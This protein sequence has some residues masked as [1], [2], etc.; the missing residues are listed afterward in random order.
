M[1]KE[2]PKRISRMVSKSFLWG[3]IAAS[4]TWSISLYLYWCLTNTSNAIGSEPTLAAMISGNHNSADQQPVA[5][6]EGKSHPNKAVLAAHEHQPNLLEPQRLDKKLY[7]EKSYS[8]FHEKLDRYNKEKQYRKISHKLMD[9]LKPIVPNGT[10]EFGMVRNSEEQFIRD[11]GYRKHAFNVLVSNKIGSFRYIPDTR[12]KLCLDQSYDKVLPSASIVMCFYNEHQQTL[13]RSVNSVIHRTPSYLLHEIVLVDDCSDYDDLKENLES[14]LKKLNSTKIKII[15]NAEREGLMRS[16]VIGARNSTGEVLIF[17]DSHIEVN[18]DWIEPLLQR[19]KVNST[20]LAMPVIDIINS[21]TFAYTSSPL[22]RGGFNWGLHFKWDNLPRGTLSKDNDFVG[23]FRSPTMAGGL[24][25][26]DRQYFKDLGEYDMGMDVW[27]GENLEISFRAWQC[28]GSIELLP[29]SRIG[30][31]FRKRRPYGSPNGAD[32]MIRNSLRLAHVWMDDYIKYYLENQPQAK[33]ID[34][35]DV[36]ERQELRNRLKCKSF[37]WYLKNIYP[38]LRLPGEKTIDSNVSQ[39]KFQPWHSR[40]RNYISS[41]QVRLSNSSLCVTTQGAKEKSLW[42]K[43][44]KLVLQPCLRVKTQMWYETE[45]SELVLGQ[46][47]CLEAPSSATKGTPILNKC[48][49]MGA[50]QAWKHRK[51][52]GTPIYNI[53]SGSCLAVKEIRKGALV[54]LDLCVNNLQSTWD[55]VIS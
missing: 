55:L 26:I 45:K 15:R 24:F 25:A 5:M 7:N 48:H 50:D 27:G 12:H 34:P 41:F 39:P 37:E 9:E 40:K 11:V 36:S 31:V 51:T 52:K 54:G 46:L 33:N 14:E 10:D 6:F 47:L 3:V 18:V 43:G 16:R 1:S 44:S 22:V 17:L 8:F 38:Q 13:I 35:G 2:K 20:I 53:A 42:K 21:D 23:P 29:C 30:H 32:T 49:E 4:L 19:I 28:G